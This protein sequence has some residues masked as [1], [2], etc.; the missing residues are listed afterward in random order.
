MWNFLRPL[1]SVKI[2]KS[3]RKYKARA[4]TCKNVTNK[5]YGIV[6]TSVYIWKYSFIRINFHTGSVIIFYCSW[7]TGLGHFY[8]DAWVENYAIFLASCVCVLE[9]IM[10]VVFLCTRARS[11][12]T[13]NWNRILQY[14]CAEIC[15]WKLRISVSNILFDNK[16]LLITEWTTTA[17]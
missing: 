13:N 6:W 8:S 15:N 14:C 16:H 9:L 5:N 12:L 11:R 4:H 3:V 17:L 1:L 2:I 7:L 10:I